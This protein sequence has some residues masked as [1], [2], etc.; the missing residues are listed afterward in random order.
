MSVSTLLII[1]DEPQLRNM[2]ERLFVGEGYHVS[3]A[4]NGAQALQRL[5]AQR[6]QAVLCDVRLPDANGVELT[7]AIKAICPGV[8]VIV[9]TAF[10]TIH[11]AVKAVQNGAFQYLVKGDDNDKLIPTVARAVEKSDLRPLADDVVKDDPFATIV[12]R[13]AALQQT[14]ELARKVA[15]T[16]ATVLLTGATGTGKEVFAQAIHSVG[17]R[18]G[19]PMLAVNCGAFSNEL[20]DSEFFGH[21]AGAFTGATRDKKG[22]IEAA[23]G[24]TLFLDE[25]G[26]LPG[27]MQAKLLRVLETG[28]YLRV[29]DIVPRKADVRIIAAT[30]R[31]LKAAITNGGFREDL[32]YRLAAFTLRIPTLAERKADIP[33]LAQHFIDRFARRMDR[34]I[35][36]MDDAVRGLLMAHTWPGHVRE[37][38]NVIERACILCEGS[39]LDAASLPLELQGGVTALRTDPVYELEL[40]EREH[41]RR[42]LHHAG[43][44]K[45]L[46]AELLGIGLT[47]L[48]AKLKKWGNEAAE[49]TAN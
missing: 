11:D 12:G 33:M 4:E 36:G 26:E 1:D 10:G 18:A 35:T 48:Y 45:T 8:E 17:R 24:G 15:G 3:T 6:F 25:V 20:L 2:L 28:D 14:V 16:D 5:K 30:H 42:V 22:L 7:A 27:A 43:G 9:L 38:R 23:R 13:S 44:N 39:T 41:I 47:T 40:V 32:Y 19:R 29:G 49:R 46:A 21:V 37:L 34:P 31:D